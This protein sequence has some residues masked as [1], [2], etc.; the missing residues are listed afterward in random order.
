MLFLGEI[1]LKR[2]D[3]DEKEQ[4]TTIY[5]F[6]N[7]LSSTQPL[8]LHG[9]GPS[10]LHL[11]AY[12][13]YVAKAWTPEDGCRHCELVTIDVDKIAEEELPI[14]YLA[15]FVEEATPFLLEQLQKVV[16]LEYPKK[17]MHCFIHNN[18]SC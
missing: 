5:E 2:I 11:N 16:K 4:S 6:N 1:Q 17:R 14:V 9:N 8:I 10:K 13:N 3:A 15:L 12:A 7:F 18:V